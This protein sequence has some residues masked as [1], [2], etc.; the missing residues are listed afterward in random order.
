MQGSHEALTLHVLLRRKPIFAPLTEEDF[1]A[2]SEVLERRQL[3]PD[4][5]L[6]QEG[7]QGDSMFIVG[8][9]TLDVSVSADIIG[10]LHVGDVTGEGA[11]IDPAPR[12]AMVR[13][14][15]KATVY[16]LTQAGLRQVL[17]LSP[18]TAAALVG[19][20]IAQISA[21]LRDTQQR[22]DEAMLQHQGLAIS[23]VLPRAEPGRA[24]VPPAP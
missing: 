23:G 1:A 19:G 20:V 5:V 22:I 15:G 9:G 16:E 6:F 3:A 10:Q 18:G 21:R 11:C 24:E 14:H 7:A 2:L 12:S 17:L 4:E 13:A 8:E